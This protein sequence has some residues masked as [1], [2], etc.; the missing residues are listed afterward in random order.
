M[1]FQ[2]YLKLWQYIYDIPSAHPHLYAPGLATSVARV[3]SVEQE[4][5]DGSFEVSYPLTVWY[6][7]DQNVG[8]LRLRFSERVFYWK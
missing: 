6:H 5:M 4:V 7:P 1:T 3:P 8:D 2:E